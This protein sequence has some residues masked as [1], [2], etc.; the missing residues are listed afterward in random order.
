M[1]LRRKGVRI[2]WVGQINNAGKLS[3]ESAILAS[4]EVYMIEGE[5]RLFGSRQI[6]LFMK[7]STDTRKFK[8]FQIRWREKLGLEESPYLIRWTIILFGYSIRLHHWIKSDDCRFYHDHSS[9]LLS[10]VL[11]GKYYNVK[12]FVKDHPPGEMVNKSGHYIRNERF[13]HVEGI[14]NS[15]YKLMNSII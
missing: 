5:V 9:D 2:P 13:Y 11:K 14:F 12:P 6:L 8:N 1:K 15:L 10:I 7:G 3:W 4:T